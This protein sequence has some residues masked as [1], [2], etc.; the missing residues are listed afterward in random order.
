MCAPLKNFGTE[1]EAGVGIAALYDKGAGVMKDY[2]Q[3]DLSALEP[4]GTS[5]RRGQFT[6]PESGRDHEVRVYIWNT[7]GQM[8]PY[9]ARR[10]DVTE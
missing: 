8:R 3:V 2:R 4:G 5:R 6:D 9:D 7:L 10:V 1:M